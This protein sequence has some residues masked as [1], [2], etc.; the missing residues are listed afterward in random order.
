M[1]LVTIKKTNADF[2]DIKKDIQILYNTISADN[3]RY[4]FQKNVKEYPN[5]VAVMAQFIPNFR[6]Y[7]STIDKIELTIDPYD[8]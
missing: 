5:K 6:Q 1:N 8:L 7:T 4:L 3:S 2:L